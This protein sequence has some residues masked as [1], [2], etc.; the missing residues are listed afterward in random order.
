MTLNYQLGMY[1]A[2]YIIGR[3]LPTLNVDMIPSNHIINVSDEEKIAFELLEGEYRKYVFGD[4]EKTI[5]KRDECFV[6]IR[7]ERRILEDKY[8]EDKLVIRVPKIQP[9]NMKE[10]KKGFD[11]AI[12]DC[13]MSHYS[14]DETFF[15][16]TNKHAWCSIIHLKRNK[17]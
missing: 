7:K 2:S 17:V 3:H 12:W 1:V 14:S 13:D 4:D 9:T 16:Q 15:V 11:E 6:N 10:F 5:R 8:L